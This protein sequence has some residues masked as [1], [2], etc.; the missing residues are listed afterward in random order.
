MAS[1]IPNAAGVH[2]AGTQTMPGQ[3][4]ARLQGLPA[5][6]ASHFTRRPD[7]L[8]GLGE[9][10]VPG[11]VVALV[12]DEGAGA[13][14]WEWRGSR[15]KSQAAAHAAMRLRRA[16]SV[17]LV[18][19][20]DTSGRASLLD[21]L[22]SAAARAGLDLAGGAEV[23]A[24]R[25]V[26]WLRATRQRWLVVLDDLRDRAD[27]AGL[28]PEGPAGITR[29]TARDPAVVAGSPAR[30]VPVGCYSQREAVAALSAWLSPDPDHRSGQLDLALALGCE[31]A[32]IAH[33]GAVISTAEL[34]CRE[35]LDLFARRRSRIEA[36]SGGEVPA[37]AVTWVLSAEHM[38][39]AGLRPW[40]GLR[41]R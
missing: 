16:G 33:A 8:G 23:A 36:A 5:P 24:A 7:T 2:A 39:P 37:A 21:G 38:A 35:Y 13:A 6:L 19:W 25:F 11:S 29:S 28:W 32:A 26:A 30:L 4:P 27:V 40:S 3:V 34:S 9:M 18:A 15:G 22:A 1:T 10:L 14:P 17:D 20:V 31:P 41:L 12:G